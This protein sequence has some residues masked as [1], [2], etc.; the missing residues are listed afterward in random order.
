SLSTLSFSCL[1]LSFLPPSFVFPCVPLCHPCYL[2]STS[3]LLF[4]S[5]PPSLPPSLLPPFLCL[6]SQ[7]DGKDIR[8]YDL[9]WLRR[10][11]AVVSQEPVLFAGSVK[12]NICYGL[13]AA[14]SDPSFSTSSSLPPSGPL[15]FPS[16]AEIEEVAR[17]ANCHDFISAFP[18]GYETLV[19]ER[20]VRLS[21][22]QKQRVA[23]A[24][25]LLVNPKVFLPP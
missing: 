9:T 7:I 4:P 20:G 17:Q 25:A 12:E 21:G 10:Q 18:E 14:Q 19:G 16:M 6:P 15:S 2:S 5:L 3:S 23:I 13:L 24:R 1:F 22:G 8:D 11:C